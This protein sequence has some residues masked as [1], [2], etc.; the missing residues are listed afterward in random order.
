M[1]SSIIYFKD[2][3]GAKYRVF[4]DNSQT[5][6]TIFNSKTLSVNFSD[7]NISSARFDFLDETILD[8]NNI[9]STLK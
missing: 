8:I 7:F 5:V 3:F 1:S 2:R 6:T 4:L 9:V